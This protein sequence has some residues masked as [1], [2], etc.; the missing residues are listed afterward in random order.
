MRQF[1]SGGLHGGNVVSDRA[2]VFSDPSLIALP[3]L[4]LLGDLPERLKVTPCQ[5][6]IDSETFRNSL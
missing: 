2:V 3:A 1:T 6:L 4:C 5:L